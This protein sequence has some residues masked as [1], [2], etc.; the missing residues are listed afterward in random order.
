MPCT[1]LFSPRCKHSADYS[2]IDPVERGFKARVGVA[3][4]IRVLC[5]TI[6]YTIQPHPALAHA[7]QVQRADERSC[8]PDSYQPR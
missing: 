4:T 6:R 1:L 3:L 7:A 2:G 5:T 8:T